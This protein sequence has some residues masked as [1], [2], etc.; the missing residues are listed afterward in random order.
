ML[1]VAPAAAAL[2]QQ[3]LDPKNPNRN[4]GPHPFGGLLALDEA[5]EIGVSP[6]KP[7]AVA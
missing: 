5:L 2:V 6:L 3:W 7:G 1:G 4:P